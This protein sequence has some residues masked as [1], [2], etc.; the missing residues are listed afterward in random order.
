MKPKPVQF[1]DLLRVGKWENQIGP[2]QGMRGYVRD[3]STE[4]KCQ[5]QCISYSAT[6]RRWILQNSWTRDFEGDLVKML[7]TAETVL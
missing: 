3:M 4:E 1:A 2:Q 7:E 5:V 6:A